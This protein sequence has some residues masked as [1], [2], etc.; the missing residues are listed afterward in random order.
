MLAVDAAGGVPAASTIP[1]SLGLLLLAVE[2]WRR[3]R[4]VAAADLSL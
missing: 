1:A 4:H 2:L 3:R